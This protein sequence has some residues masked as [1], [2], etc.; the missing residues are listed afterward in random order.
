MDEVEIDEKTKFIKIKP[1]VTSN[2]LRLTNEL[3]KNFDK[4][5]YA[6]KR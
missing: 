4:F 1:N 2:K 5:K 6:L 3:P